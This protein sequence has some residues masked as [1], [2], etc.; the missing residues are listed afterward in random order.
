[1]LSVQGAILRQRFCFQ[2]Q[3]YVLEPGPK[4]ERVARLFTLFCILA[5][6][7]ALVMVNSPC[8]DAMLWNQLQK[9]KQVDILAVAPLPC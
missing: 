2:W 7:K 1:M 3:L 5:R 9:E 8:N 6:L 4:F